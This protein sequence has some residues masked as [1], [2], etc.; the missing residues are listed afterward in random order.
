MKKILLLALLCAL[1]NSLKAQNTFP[2]SGSVGIGTTSPGYTLDVNGTVHFANSIINTSGDLNS[3]LGNGS[4]AG[5]NLTNS[6]SGS[7]WVMVSNYSNGYDQLFQLAY[8]QYQSGKL[9]TRYSASGGSTWNTWKTIINSDALSGTTNYISKFTGSNS[10]GN[11]LIYDNGTNVGIGTTDTHGYKFAVNGDIHTKKVVV[12]LINWPDYVFKPTYN[13]K[14]LSEVKSYID[15]N[16]HLPEM[17]SEKEIA[18]KGVDLGEMNKLL[19]KKIEE[20]TLYL[21]DKDKENKQQQEQINDLKEQM[22]KVLEKL[23]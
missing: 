23:K 17:P 15:L 4:Y 19:T 12:D 20:L 14:P 16:H 3:L 10:I 5:Y 18:E 9:F 8:D 21:I 11:S 13:L 22:A 6:P 1:A 2:S 7:G